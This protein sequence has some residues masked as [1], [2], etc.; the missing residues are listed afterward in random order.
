MPHHARGDFARAGARLDGILVTHVS[1]IVKRGDG[2]VERM[3]VSGQ[4][5]ANAK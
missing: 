5:F 1:S 2:F 3:S 4:P